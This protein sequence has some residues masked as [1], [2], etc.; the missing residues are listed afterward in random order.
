[1]ACLRTH[2]NETY[3]G[4]LVS[5]EECFLHNEP[6]FNWWMCFFRQYDLPFCRQSYWSTHEETKDNFKYTINIPKAY[7]RNTIQ[8]TLIQKEGAPPRSKQYVP[9][10][11]RNFTEIYDSLVITRVIQIALIMDPWNRVD[12]SPIDFISWNYVKV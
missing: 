9:D 7:Y 2:P 12:S 1:M 11:L 3:L 5:V 4:T 8:S 10:F 6:K